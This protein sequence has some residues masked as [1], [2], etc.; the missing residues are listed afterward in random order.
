MLTLHYDKKT[1]SIVFRRDNQTERQETLLA[2]ILFNVD[3]QRDLSQ[4]RENLTPILQEA[5]FTEEE[6]QVAL[7]KNLV[8][9]YFSLEGQIPKLL[10]AG[11]TYLENLRNPP[12]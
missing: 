8:L 3:N 12:S 5:E 1:H 4:I 9:A 6:Y 2:L 10:D 7:E 11:K